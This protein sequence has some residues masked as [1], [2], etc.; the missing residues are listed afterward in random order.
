MKKILSI[1]GSDSSGGA[2]IQADLKTIAAHKAFGMTAITALTAQNTLGV[3]AI[4]NVSPEFLEKEI[5]AVFTDIMP[6]AVK[7]GM[8]SNA[9]LI[10]MIV[11]KLKEYNARNIVVDPVMI[12]TSGSNLLEDS[13]I[14]ALKNELIPIGTLITPNLF[15]AAVLSGIEIKNIND[16]HRAAKIIGDE[17]QVAVLIK[18]GHLDSSKNDVLYTD[19]K[20]VVI[21]GETIDNPNT[22]G[23][24]CTLSSAIACNLANGL[25]IIDSCIQGKEYITGAI[26]AKLDLGNGRGPLN[27][28]WAYK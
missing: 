5:D 23:T 6:D 26:N 25:D 4:E 15:E 19:N 1:A 16:M 7:I 18:G 9:E 2:G 20:I 3:T 10:H 11:S 13:A 17:N 14:I 8:V 27:H 22:H 24:G 28:M 21:N 12:A